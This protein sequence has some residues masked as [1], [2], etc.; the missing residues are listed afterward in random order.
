MREIPC[1]RVRPVRCLSDNLAY[2]VVHD[3][4]AV[5]VDPGEA[6]PMRA[7][8]AEEGAELVEIWCTHHHGDH[9]GGVREL[10]AAFPAARIVASLHDLTAGR[11]PEH[12]ARGVGTGAP[13]AGAE[14]GEARAVGDSTTPWRPFG[15][16]GPDVRVLEVPGHTLGAVTFVV[17][18][19]AFT[20]DT[21][22]NAGCGRL[23]EGT[24]A[25]M[26]AS[27]TRLR[28][29]PAETRVWSGH[30]YTTANLA[31]ARGLL[32]DDTALARRAAAVE[33]ERS[34]GGSTTGAPLAEER[35]SNLFLRWDDPEVAALAARI[36]PSLPPR[37]WPDSPED[38][39]FAVLRA[40]KDG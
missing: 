23:F 8:L 19:H 32:P 13:R 26:R 21:L 4:R 35:A 14:V 36:V 5:V 25:Q 1:V 38:R 6:A 27:L 10:R 3:G 39:T 9:V 16:H 30:S 18:G 7:A 31:W 33:A 34:A 11:I 17:G 40:H 28:A 24:P 22:F 20:G 29:L 15:P 2:L 12:R 37:P